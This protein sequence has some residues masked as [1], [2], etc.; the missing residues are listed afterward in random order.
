M[1][2]R[3]VVPDT[4]CL[5][6]LSAMSRLDL[7]DELYD[8]VVVPD[9]VAQEF[10]EPLPQWAKPVHGDPLVIAALR[11][12][13]GH[14]E[15]EVIAVAAQSADALAVLDDKRARAT[16]R[17]MGVRLTGTLGI[18]LRAKRE[19]RLP[20]MRAALDVLERA[21]FHMSSELRAKACKLAGE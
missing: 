21:G 11:E 16:A 10:A 5:I 8:D 7:L 13:L 15:A 19:G 17:A 4:T 14:G 18:L 20:S 1:P 2:D 9:A 12:S 3:R 6:A